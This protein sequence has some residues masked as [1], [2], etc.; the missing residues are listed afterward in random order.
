LIIYVSQYSLVIDFI[1][2]DFYPTLTY[3]QC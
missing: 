1:C 3:G 2:F